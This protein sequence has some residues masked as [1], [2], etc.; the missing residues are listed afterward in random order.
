VGE[1]RRELVDDLN[2]FLAV[3]KDSLLVVIV[4]VVV[5]VGEREWVSK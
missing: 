5:V 1:L 3:F 4:S 2:D